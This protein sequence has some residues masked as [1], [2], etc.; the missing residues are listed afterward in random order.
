MKK[1]APAPSPAALP[2]IL[3]GHEEWDRQHHQLHGLLARLQALTANPAQIDSEAGRHALLDI[4]GETLA[5][6][7]EHFRWEEALMASLPINALTE[8]HCIFHRE[9]HD[10][11]AERMGELAERADQAS[12]R[13]SSD[14]LA[15][16]LGEWLTNHIRGYD[17][18][19][20]R[21]LTADRWPLKT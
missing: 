11:I 2:E 10:S 9:E 7:V 12:V 8:A 20:L 4:V 21:L 1:P 15:A 18:P 16:L 6:M 5:V 13:E 14:S 3:T 19:F 17:Q